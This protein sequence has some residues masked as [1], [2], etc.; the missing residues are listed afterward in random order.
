MGH[1]CCSS[2]RVAPPNHTHRAP[3]APCRARQ[4]RCS[5]TMQLR[6]ADTRE[7]A[8]I[9]HG[10]LNHAAR[11]IPPNNPT[12]RAAHTHTHWGAIKPPRLGC[13]RYARARKGGGE[14]RHQRRRPPGRRAAAPPT[15]PRRR[16]PAAAPQQ[17]H[18]L[19][20]A[21]CAAPAAHAP[22]AVLGARAGRPTLSAA[23]LQSSSR[24]P[25][26]PPRAARQRK[27]RFKNRPSNKAALRHAH[28]QTFYP[29]YRFVSLA[30]SPPL[31][32]RPSSRPSRPKQQV[33]QTLHPPPLSAAAP[34]KHL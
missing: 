28:P 25:A 1:T 5:T 8:A 7:T 20:I 26:L 12:T 19:R 13:A 6:G 18:R 4:Q 32:A 34:H 33:T 14:G 30:S 27:L 15:P 3:S 21:R 2:T 11:G 23:A 31:Q 24:F 29:S 9:C 17:P 16:R 22:A 10:A